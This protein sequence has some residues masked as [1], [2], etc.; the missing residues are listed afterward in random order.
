MFSSDYQY[1]RIAALLTPRRKRF[2]RELISFIAH[3]RLA[4]DGY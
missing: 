4:V 3:A 1:I 2:G